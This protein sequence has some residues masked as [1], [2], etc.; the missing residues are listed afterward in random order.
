MWV[1]FR[2]IEPYERQ[3]VERKLYLGFLG[4]AALSVVAFAVEW[5]GQMRIGEGDQ[6]IV[7]QPVIH[8]MIMVMALNHP[9]MRKHRENGFYGAALGLS[10][11]ATHGMLFLLAKGPNWLEPHDLVFLIPALFGMT[12]FLG[13][14]GAY[15]GTHTHS[16]DKMTFIARIWAIYILYFLLFSLH[17]GIYRDW[18]DFTGRALQGILAFA[19]IFLGTLAYYHRYLSSLKGVF[20]HRRR[21]RRPRKKG[22]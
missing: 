10:F 14:V 21:R 7:G 3:L 18:N 2:T 11:G 9:R 15:I 12:L 20:V 4:G 5:F 8:I 1:L 17:Y 13:S 19:L 6:S 22:R 16:Q